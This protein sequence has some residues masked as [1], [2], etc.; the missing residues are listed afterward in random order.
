MNESVDN[1]GDVWAFGCVIYSLLSFK[2]PF[3]S[4]EIKETLQNI[5]DI[6]IDY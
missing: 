6:K 5:V 4:S 2:T 1:K 3:E